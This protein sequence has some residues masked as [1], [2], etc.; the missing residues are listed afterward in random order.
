[1][2]QIKRQPSIPEL[3]ARCHLTWKRHMARQCLPHGISLKQYHL[4]NLL[5]AG[6]LS[7]LLAAR[8]LFCDKPTASVI[9]GNL[10]RQGL[11]ERR[12][13]ARD[14]RGAELLIT[15]KGLAKL[16]T[17]AEAGGLNR[18]RAP[19]EC[20]SAAEAATLRELLRK[21][22]NHLETTLAGDDHE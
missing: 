9:L 20:L 16:E 5:K 13:N 18:G 14:R 15:E 3:L 19:R 12:A 8:E 7:P 11:A 2:T 4:L 1:M 21:I 22:Y 10:V 6:P 17:I